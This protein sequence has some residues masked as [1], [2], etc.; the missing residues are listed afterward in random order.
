MPGSGGGNRPSQAFRVAA[1]PSGTLF[2]ITG[3]GTFNLHAGG[4]TYWAAAACPADVLAQFIAG[5]VFGLWLEVH[6]H[7]VLHGAALLVRE[8]GVAILAH[9]GTGKSTLAAAL[10]HRGATLLT[11]D[12]VVLASGGGGLMVQPGRAQL[13]LWPD[14]CQRLG[15]ATAHF[16]PVHSHTEKLVVPLAPTHV[17]TTPVPLTRIVLLQRAGGAGPISVR[18]LSKPD[19]VREVVQCSAAPR[20]VEA[21]G[22]HRR[23][24]PVIA[25]VVNQTTVVRLTFSTA[26]STPDD[27]AA[28]LE[29]LCQA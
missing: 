25:N 15:L 27:V 12:Q 6:G 16:R 7:V 9:G 21:L 3:V 23:R 5:P 28:A 20:M 14:A 11:D 19:A 18:P 29:A 13:K 17:T 22:L 1:R 8:T 10:V 24:F 26:V 4:I 2:R